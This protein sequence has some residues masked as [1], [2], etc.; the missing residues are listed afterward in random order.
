V[1]LSITAFGIALGF[2]TADSVDAACLA[3]SSYFSGVIR[4]YERGAQATTIAVGLHSITVTFQSFGIFAYFITVGIA[5]AY[6]AMFCNVITSPDVIST[7]WS[8]IGFSCGGGTAAAAAG[9]F[10]E[11]CG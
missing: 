11:G 1:T 2:G 7:A 4:P 6:V 9:F 8:A 5:S 10:F 3:K